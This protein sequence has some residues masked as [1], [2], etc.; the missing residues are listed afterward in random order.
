MHVMVLY[1]PEALQYVS[2]F[3]LFIQWSKSISTSLCII[4]QQLPFKGELMFFTGPWGLGYNM[5]LCTAYLHIIADL[6]SKGTP[7]VLQQ[8]LSYF[9]AITATDMFAWLSSGSKFS[10]F[11]LLSKILFIYK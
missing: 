11:F 5:K 2:S 8:P 3:Q 1:E 10:A 9:P 4:S 6:H 7:P